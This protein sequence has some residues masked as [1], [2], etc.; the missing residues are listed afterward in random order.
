MTTPNPLPN[1]QP[2]P[3]VPKAVLQT[4]IETLS[5]VQAVWSTDPSPDLGR[6]AGTER[7]WII[8]N[9]QSFRNVGTDELRQAYDPTTDSNVNLQLGNRQFTLSCGARSLDATLEAYDLLE[10]VRFRLRTATARAIFAPA[11]L[12]LRDIQAVQVLSG[13]VAGTQALKAASMD[14]RWNWMA[15]ADPLD[16][17]QGDYIA[18]VNGDGTTNG[19]IPFNE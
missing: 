15:A 8:L 7:A 19:T 10:R 13:K 9:L 12:S 4:L 1:I 5:G 3:R 11:N 14:V 16:P 6:R 17:G 2:S 18:T